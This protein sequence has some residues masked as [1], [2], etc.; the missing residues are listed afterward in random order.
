MYRSVRPTQPV[1]VE[2]DGSWYAGELQA[3]RT[4]DDGAWLAFVLYGVA[5]GDEVPR[6]GASEAGSAT[7]DRRVTP[8]HRTYIARGQWKSGNWPLTC[9][10]VGG[11]SR[12][13]T[14]DH[15]LVREVLYR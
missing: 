6:L 15:L 9:G 4:D 13:R 7:C 3:W 11:R 8:P 12:D 2:R 10:Y 5:A 1:E 14:C